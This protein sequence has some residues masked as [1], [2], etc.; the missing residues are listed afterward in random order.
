LSFGGRS[1]VAPHRGYDK[2]DRTSRFQ[3]IAH[4]PDDERKVVD[5]AAADADRDARAWP[6]ETIERRELRA[7]CASRIIEVRSIEP[8]PDFV[9]PHGL[10]YRYLALLRSSTAAPE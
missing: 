9:E 6:D 4:L 7:Q 5:S 8:L 1:A 3:I 10:Q 2:R